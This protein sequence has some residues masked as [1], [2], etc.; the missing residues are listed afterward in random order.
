MTNLYVCVCCVGLCVCV[1]VHACVSTKVKFSLSSEIQ[2]YSMKTPIGNCC[3][4]YKSLSLFC[5]C[6]LLTL[7]NF[8]FILSLSGSS[9]VTRDLAEYHL[10]FSPSFNPKESVRE[11]SLS[12]RQVPTV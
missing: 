5:L 2:D 7:R 9:L 6:F 8:L 11:Y 4:E 12:H 3:L 1:C 10:L